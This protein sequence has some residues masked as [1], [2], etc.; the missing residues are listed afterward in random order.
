MADAKV[1]LSVDEATALAIR[2]CV[3][4]GASLPAAR[5]LATATLSAE[6]EGKPGL[7]FPH[8]LDYLAAMEAGRIDPRAEPELSA[9]LPA[10]IHCD[11][12]DGIA[13]LGFD[14]AFD[15][16]V[17]AAGALG[18]A[19]FSQN[20][21]FTAGEIGYY[22]RRLAKAG[23]VSIAFANAQALMAPAPGGRKAF[24]TN[25]LAFGV[26]LG[27]DAAPLVFDQASSATAFVNILRAAREG[28][29][30][31][32]GWAVDADGNPT[33]DAVKAADGALLPAGGYKGANIALMVEMM[34]AG[35][36]GAS[37][38][39]D[40]GTFNTGHTPPRSGMTIIVIKPDAIDPAFLS[41]CKAHMERLV[42]LGVRRPGSR[43]G[44]KRETVTLAPDTLSRL[45]GA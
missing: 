37:W 19:I 21:S 31:P 8:F 25:P 15:R 6:L 35:Y 4:R 44:E 33:T 18:V 12:K 14:L 43:A 3:D 9:P 27:A 40:A 41:R 16:L 2:A 5:A 28:E 32:E 23:F 38:S 11:A 29:A 30:I 1:E 39:A 20:N 45:K 10:I 22:A 42:T 24:S 34:A 17:D 26:P 7:G 36:A 13:Q